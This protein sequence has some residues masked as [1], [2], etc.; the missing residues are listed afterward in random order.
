MN[1]IEPMQ[2]EEFRAIREMLGLTQAELGELLAIGPQVVYRK[3]AGKSFI[4]PP[5]AL[6]MRGLLLELVTQ[7][8]KHKNCTIRKRTV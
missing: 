6:A 7:L 5:T 3:E 2:P 8:A 4:D 1:P